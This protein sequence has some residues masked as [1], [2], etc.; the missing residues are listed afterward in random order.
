MTAFAEVD[1]PCPRFRVN[2]VRR[3]RAPSGPSRPGP[4]RRGAF[5]LAAVLALSGCATYNDD[6]AAVR[7]SWNLG[8]WEGAAAAGARLARDDPDHRNAVL[9]GLEEGTVLRAVRRFDASQDTYESTWDRIQE[10]DLRA[11][12]RISQAG[13]SLLVNP[14]LTVYEARTYDR[15]M[16]HA[17]SALNYLEL[18]DPGAARVALNRAY[19][20]QQSA[21]AENAERIRQTKEEIEEKR[22]DDSGQVDLGKIADAPAT[23]AKLAALYEPVRSL[24]P[25]APYVNPFAV[26]LDGLFF[27]AHATDA[28][29]LERG[30][31]SMERVSRLNP[32]SD[33]LAEE[34][35]LAR[36][37]VAGKGQPPSVVVLFE[38]G[39]A[40]IRAAET[41][42]LPLFLFGSGSVPYFAAAFPVLRFQDP[43]PETLRVRAGDGTASTEVIADMDRVIAQEFRDHESLV[44]TQALLSGATKAAVFYAARSQ[45]KDDSAAQ[46]FID[47]AGIFYQ[48]ATN[49]PDLRTWFT[50]PKQFQG[51]RLPMPED[52]TLTLSFPP[53]NQKVEV[54]LEEGKVVV[55]H[56]RVTATP[57]DPVVHQFPLVP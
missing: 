42:E 32:R 44:V 9:F 38:T 8:A 39:L 14:G 57:A 41:L 51:I 6:V 22:A 4:G 3:P 52:R 34:H 5:L 28:S 2:G 29:D 23:Q 12:F 50:L 46:A 21:V 11:E 1:P 25:Y 30:L 15:I 40:P 37:I 18:E 54:S 20:A 33:W 10:M 19:D 43:F 27:L 56:V 24:E 45:A 31:K 16:L 55:V 35:A 53:G 47:I 17:Y 26:Y 7:K 13:L 36:R 48:A 49:H